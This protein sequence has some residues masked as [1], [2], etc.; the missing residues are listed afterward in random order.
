MRWSLT[1]QLSLEL[2]ST[3][4]SLLLMQL[5]CQFFNHLLLLDQHLILLGVHPVHASTVPDSEPLVAHAASTKAIIHAK[6]GWR[7]LQGELRGRGHW[8]VAEAVRERAAE[9]QLR[10]R[11][12][13]GRGGWSAWVMVIA[14]L[15]HGTGGWRRLV[16][17]QGP[18]W[19]DWE[20]HCGNV[21]G[22]RGRWAGVWV[23]EWAKS[24]NQ[25]CLGARHRHAPN[26]QVLPE[27]WDLEHRR[28]RKRHY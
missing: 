21:G 14:P 27:L 15:R 25:G 16:W 24:L 20:G 11:R 9:G 4:L 26:T 10:G 5:P 2:L 13:Y 18:S 3:H 1:L 12:R 22:V 28:Q 19:C 6:L 8:H 23:F 7:W 17:G